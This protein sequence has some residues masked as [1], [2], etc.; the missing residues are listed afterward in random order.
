MSEEAVTRVLKNVC[1]LFAGTVSRMLLS[2]ALVVYAARELGVESFGK[3]ALTQHFF[4]FAVSM[5]ATAIGIWLTREVAGKADA[6]PSHLT[7]ATILAAI[8]C[9]PA[10]AT[11]LIAPSVMGYASDTRLAMAVAAAGVIPAVA[12][13]L[14]EAVFL[15]LERAKFIT[16]GTLLES[17][18]RI[19]AS[20][21]LIFLGYGIVPLFMVIVWSRTLTLIYYLFCLRRVVPS[22]GW[23]WNRTL[24]LGYLGEWWVFALENWTTN[25]RKGIPV[26]VLSKYSGETAVGLFVAAAKVLRLGIVAAGSFTQA[27]YPYLSRLHASSGVA[28]QEVSSR[29]LQYLIVAVLPAV[30]IVS[31]LADP[32]ILL[33][34]SS[35][36]APSVTILQITIWGLLL[37]FLNPF[38]SYALFA[39]G[40]QN[41]SLRVALIQFACCLTA[42]LLLIPTF[43]GVGAA[44]ATVIPAAIA[45]LIYLAFFARGED[46]KTIAT[47]LPRTLLPSVVLAVFLAIAHPWHVAIQLV[48]SA[49]IYLALV[50]GLGVVSI[51]DLALLSRLRPHGFPQE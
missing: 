28:F 37:A 42:S 31:F 39:R 25:L 26:I 5:V 14:A 19:A 21:L 48:F 16:G 22:I 45:L 18:V 13:V 29:A 50:V 20:F 6:I 7:A 4:D 1:M 24:A 30:V 23:S 51:G 17:L 2:F 44:F 15:G 36:Y 46:W 12:C 43:G 8:L 10:I 40:D 34:Y 11:L 49:A 33:L 27:M 35:A 9:L 38:L 3:Y 32:I 47:A 41:S